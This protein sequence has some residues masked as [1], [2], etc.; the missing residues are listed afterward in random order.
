MNS[1]QMRKTIRLQVFLI[2][3]IAFS[4]CKN[5]KKGILHEKFE[6]KISNEIESFDSK[7][8]IYERSY[9][10][11]DTAIV[12]NFKEEELEEINEAFREIDF[13]AFPTNFKCSSNSD[14]ISPSRETSISLYLSETITKTVTSTTY[15]PEKENQE[16]SEKFENL[17]NSIWEIIKNKESVKNLKPSDI[18]S[19]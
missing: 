13:L 5:E 10:Q 9:V 12:I 16:Q 7:S 6:Y 1:Q 11:A 14:L 19:I 2:I 8:Q 4:S 17:K 18:I 15:C 3:L